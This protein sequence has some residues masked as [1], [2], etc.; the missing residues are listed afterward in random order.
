M[1]VGLSGLEEAD[2][3]GKAGAAPYLP[4]GKFS[5]MGDKELGSKANL[6]GELRKASRFIPLPSWS[7]SSG[8]GVGVR[9]G[10]GIGR[11][12]AIAAVRWSRRA[13]CSGSEEEALID[14]V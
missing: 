4:R 2:G 8:G 14:N 3:G 12:D 6:A 1:S 11:L 10:A 9:G 13:T 7:S 5:S